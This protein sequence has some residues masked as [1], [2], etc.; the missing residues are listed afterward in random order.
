MAQLASP[1]RRRAAAPARRRAPRRRSRRWW[2]GP[3]RRWIWRRRWRRWRRR[4]PY[5]PS[6]RIDAGATANSAEQRC[7]SSRKP[8]RPRARMLRK[9]IAALISGASAMLSMAALEPSL[10][11]HQKEL[12]QQMRNAPAGQRRVQ[13]RTAWRG[14]CATTSRRRSLSCPASPMTPTPISWAAIL[15]RA[16]WSSLGGGPRNP[17]AQTNGPRPQPGLGGGDPRPRRLMARSDHRREVG[18]AL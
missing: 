11:P 15:N 17:N 5:G 6:A 4:E 1:V 13:V 16:I 2:R 10:T 9:T 14:C 18:E 12:L 7:S 8:T 3:W